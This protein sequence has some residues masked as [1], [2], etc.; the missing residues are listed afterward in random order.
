MV[1]VDI[2]RDSDDLDDGI[3]RIP[4]TLAEF[5]SY[6][7]AHTNHGYDQM[8]LLMPDE[9]PIVDVS[10]RRVGHRLEV[11]LGDRPNGKGGGNVRRWLSGGGRHHRHDRSIGNVRAAGEITHRS[12]E[13]RDMRHGGP[14]L[15]CPFCRPVGPYRGAGPEVGR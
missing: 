8:D 13:H 11:Y 6:L 4:L 3:E 15:S 9:E 12:R 1:S 5:L 7:Y 10:L 2:N 14:L